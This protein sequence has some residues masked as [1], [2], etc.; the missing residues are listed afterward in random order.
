MRQNEYLKR[1]IGHIIG[2]NV[3]KRMQKV[4]N[5]HILSINVAG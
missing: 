3:A 5:S 4:A 1:A 2:E